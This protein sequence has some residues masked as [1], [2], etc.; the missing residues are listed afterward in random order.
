MKNLIVLL[1]V[2]GSAV[3]YGQVQSV[4]YMMKY[5]C[6][7]NK[8]DVSLN[9][10][11]GSAST[12]PQR[13]QFNA[14]ISIVVPAGEAI[15][16]TNKYMPLQS[17]QN[18]DGTAPLDWGLSN[19]IFTPAAQPENDFYS[20]VPKL[21]PASFYN[22]MQQGDKV[23]L[24]SFTSGATGQYNENVRFFKNGTDPN[25][26]SPGMGGGDFSNGFSIGGSTQ[27]YN[28]NIEESCLTAVGENIEIEANVYPN[29]FASQFTIELPT[30]IKS[31]RI[32]NSE[33]KVHYQS[34]NKSKGII[35]IN[36]YDYTSGI[37][38][39]RIETENGITSRR[40]VK[41]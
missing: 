19:P 21:A 33:G 40:L 36:A 11:E 29:P 41:F 1:L 4:D 37:Y 18:Y 20:V 9:I 27:L 30:D 13:A 38:Y 12:I 26:T 25:H 31:I 5:N 6:E 22:N 35:I 15:V 39:L 28:G 14:Q 3:S 10:L 16:I 23:T 34:A 2:F 17:N 8:Y 7:T 24:F 32:I